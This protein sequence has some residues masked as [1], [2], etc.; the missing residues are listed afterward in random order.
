MDGIEKSS[1]IAL[2]NKKIRE[3][4]R[5]NQIYRLALEN[6]ANPLYPYDNG[7]L[8]RQSLLKS[9]NKKYKPKRLDDC[10]FDVSY[11]QFNLFGE[12]DE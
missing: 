2:N 3:L 9:S 6:Y 5:K 12:T 4:E 8:A 1:L 7:E 11:L 10:T